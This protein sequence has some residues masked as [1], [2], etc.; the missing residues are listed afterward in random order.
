[1][2]QAG[3]LRSCQVEGH[4]HSGLPGDDIVCAAVSVLTRTL[5]GVLS[6]REDIRVR[7]SIPERGHFS[8]EA[9]YSPQGREYLSA[10]GDFLLEGL[11]SVS[12]EYPD[13][14]RLTIE[15]RS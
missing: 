13:N 6:Q 15:R 9:E 1:M 12:A 10:A 8:M 2:D 7:G 4:A 11:H 14:C 5:L 3:L